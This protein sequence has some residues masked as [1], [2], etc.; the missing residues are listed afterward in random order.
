MEPAFSTV[1][2]RITGRSDRCRPGLRLQFVGR[3]KKYMNASRPPSEHPPVRGEDVITFRWDHR[4]QIQNLS[5][6]F[7]RVP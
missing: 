5:M 4:L 2:Q 1:A 6:A 3:L 7:K